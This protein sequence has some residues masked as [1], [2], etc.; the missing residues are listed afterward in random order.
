M[1]KVLTPQ[2]VQQHSTA[3]DAWVILDGK[4]YNITTFLKYH[5]GG[6]DILL[7]KAA[8]KDATSLFYKYHPHV[9]GHN[10]L[11][12]CLVGTL[13]QTSVPVSSCGTSDKPANGVSKVAKSLLAKLQ[14]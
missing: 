4:V 12:K 6:P 14:F 9:K 7:K 13:E 1:T 11:S 2:Q 5:P 3:D 10:M 8:G